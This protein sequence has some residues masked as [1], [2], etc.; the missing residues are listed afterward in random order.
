[1]EI[2]SAWGTFEWLLADCFERGYRCGVVCNSDDHKGRPGASHPGAAS[3]ATYGGL[4]C[5]LAEA[6]T[7]EAL[8]DCIR[9]RHT[10][11]TTGC[12]MGLDVRAIFATSGRSYDRDPHVGPSVARDVTE[13]MMG[14]IAQTDDDCV[15]V[16]VQVMSHAPID[17]IEIINGTD[18]VET[19]RGYTEADLGHRIRVVWSGAEYRG[20]GNRTRWQGQARFEGCRIQSMTEIN[21]W[22]PERRFKVSGNHTIAWESQTAGNFCGFDVHLNSPGFRGACS[23]TRH[24]V[25]LVRSTW[26]RWV[27]GTS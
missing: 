4:T 20:R 1:M 14:D 6:L 8:F 15:S 9:R 24:L 17:R 23:S 3:F 7:R 13:V 12:R 11:G 16:A 27:C 21:N 19:L 25:Y 18:V 5:F 26:K 2:H 22:H 10:Y